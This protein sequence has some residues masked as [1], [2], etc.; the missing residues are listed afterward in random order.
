MLTVKLDKPE[1]P[2]FHIA[3][4]FE[5]MTDNVS[6]QDFKWGDL[7]KIA[8]QDKFMTSS[9]YNAFSEGEQDK[10]RQLIESTL[11]QEEMFNNFTIE[12][13]EQVK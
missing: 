11:V 2:E 8:M 7:K 4:E 6:I 12:E 1:L 10:L 13:K 5:L 3:Q 9:L